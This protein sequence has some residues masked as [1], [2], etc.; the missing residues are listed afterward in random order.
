MIKKSKI[1]IV[2]ENVLNCETMDGILMIMNL[3]DRAN[4]VEYALNGIEA[5]KAIPY[6]HKSDQLICHSYCLIVIDCSM[7]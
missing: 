6:S 4:C 7:K 3:Q 5:L 2:D 1:L